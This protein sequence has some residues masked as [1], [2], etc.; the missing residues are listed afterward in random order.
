M[1]GR[2]LV[3]EDNE[4]LARMYQKVLRHNEFDTLVTA[5]AQEAIEF[6]L[7]YA[8]DIVLLDWMLL[9]GTSERF[10]DYVQGLGLAVAPRI[11]VVSAEVRRQDLEPYS[12]L[13]ESFFAKPV[14]PLELVARIL[15]G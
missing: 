6:F 4:S 9:D 7:D 15:E 11:I 10:L 8:P 1:N 3:V 14:S 13:V 12:H 2:V 5:T